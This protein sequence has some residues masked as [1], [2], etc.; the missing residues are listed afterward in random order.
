M[1]YIGW[2]IVVAGAVLML[3]VAA[4]LGFTI[5]VVGMIMLLVEKSTLR[6]VVAALA[7]IG[8]IFTIWGVDHQP[9]AVIGLV[10]MVVLGPMAIFWP[11][12]STDHSRQPLRRRR[13]VTKLHSG[14]D[15]E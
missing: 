12:Q 1:R 15:Y 7:V 6:E 8:F 11:K 5:G 4:S 3:T 13:S 10:A 2:L 14:L 9:A